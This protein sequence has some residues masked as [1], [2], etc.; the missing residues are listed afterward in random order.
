MP[1]IKDIAREAGV[2][3]GTVSNVLNGR[4]NV[5]VEKI[6]LVEDAARRLGYQLNARA[7]TLR[8]GDSRAAAVILPGLDQ[9]QY[10]AFYS[11]LEQEL[12]RAGY[13]V[14]LYQTH[15]RVADERAAIADALASRASLLVTS[16]R[17]PDAAA[18]YR[19]AQP[20]PAVV[21]L[22]HVPEPLPVNGF[23]AGFDLREAGQETGAFLARHGAR[24]A[25]VFT[26]PVELTHVRDFLGGLRAALA[27]AGIPL[28]E[29]AST[30]ALTANRAFELFEEG[31]P[32]D[33]V[34]CMDEKRR[35]AARA[36]ASFAG[37]DCVQYVTLAPRRAVSPSDE[38]VYELDYKRLAHRLVKNLSRD[39]MRP[40]GPDA[41]RL[42]GP[43]FKCRHSDLSCAGRTLRFLTVASPASTALSRLLPH[44]TRKTGVHVEL[45]VLSLGDLYDVVSTMGASAQ[46]DLVRM[47]M[48]WISELAPRVYAP[49]HAVEYDW[50][51]LLPRLLPVFLDDYTTADRVRCCLPYDPSTQLLFYRRDLFEDPIVRRMYYEMFREEL[52]VPRDFAEYNQVARFFTQSFHAQSPT[53]YGTTAAIGNAV[54]SPSEYLPRLFGEGGS[55]FDPAG[56]IAL[57]TPAARRALKNYV[58]TYR[59]SDRTVYDW[60]KG[61]LEGFTS[62]AAAMTIVFMNYASDLV[63]A[64]LTSIAGKIGF[65]PVPGAKPLVG[66]GV[67]GINR[68]SGQAQTACR[69]LDWLYSDEIACVFTM[70][71]G[72]SPCRAVY[73]NR[74]VLDLYPWLS[75][76][77]RSFSIGQRRLSSD[78]YQDFSEK[79]LEELLSVEVKKAV[80]GVLSPEEALRRAQR[81]C[82]QRFHLL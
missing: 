62:G 31:S 5:S 35:D 4:G 47:D 71:G 16:T 6:R 27:A 70:L 18:R 52:A 60:W 65:A 21:F 58:E 36:A 15:A 75:E 72:L 20:G 19:F 61:V 17:L 79:A 40:D 10:A 67:I 11:V 63:S 2:S 51:G 55:I 3:H 30:D 77:K 64:K 37:E 48:A 66:G 14:Q 22:D 28:R 44:F 82:A 68:H 43:G 46:Y 76:A 49:L 73:S 80:T 38:A 9:T 33:F 34:V 8:Q 57:E 23:S 69:F 24:N 42:T 25:A 13:A 54:T 74:D 45:T 12:R 50:D 53:K 59:Y 32:P 7:H 41:L 26:P 56:R 81:A 39:P 29:L 78:R 1:T